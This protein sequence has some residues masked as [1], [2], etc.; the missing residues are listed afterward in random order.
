[1]LLPILII[2]LENQTLD[3]SIKERNEQLLSDYPELIS[4]FSLLT[5]AGLST[6]NALYRIA[7]DYSEALANGSDRRYVYDEIVLTCQRL[8]NGTHEA[9]AYEEMGQRFALPCYIKFS[10]LLSSCL[11]RGTSDF[12]RLLAEEAASS[13]LEKKASVLQKGERASSKLMGPMM[14]MF[15][16]ILVLVMVPAL[17]TINI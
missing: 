10:S 7:D 8:K 5:V 2:A 14:L 15:I 3:K 6:S 12:N 17:L 11:K 9:L 13:L 4:K 16:V 1:M